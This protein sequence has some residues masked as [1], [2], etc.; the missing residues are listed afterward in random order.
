[1]NELESRESVAMWLNRVLDD[2]W[3]EG[4]I[5]TLPY[6]TESEEEELG[7]HLL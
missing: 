7:P 5:R 2:L 4:H 6:F 1:M 3:E